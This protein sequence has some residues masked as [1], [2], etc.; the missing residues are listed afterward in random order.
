MVIL[1]IEDI[2]DGVIM[3]MATK[4]LGHKRSVLVKSGSR[5]DWVENA[6][7]R[8]DVTAIWASGNG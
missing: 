1:K 4:T 8:N 3:K 2:D 7:M 6:I 5:I